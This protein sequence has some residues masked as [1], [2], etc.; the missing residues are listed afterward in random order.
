[1]THTV[2]MTSA[3]NV[4][5]PRIASARAGSPAVGGG[6]LLAGLTMF[7]GLLDGVR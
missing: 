1:M 6:L 5:D 7:A 4:L 3:H 2:R